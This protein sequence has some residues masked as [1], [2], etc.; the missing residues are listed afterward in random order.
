MFPQGK[1][2]V[3]QLVGKYNFDNIATA[4]C[5]GKFFAYCGDFIGLLI[6][7]YKNCRNTVFKRN[8]ATKD[9]VTA[10]TVDL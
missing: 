7:L 2:V 4:L 9:I 8:A 5:I 3:T 6:K 1:T 10:N